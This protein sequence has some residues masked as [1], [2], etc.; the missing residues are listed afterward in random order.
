MQRRCANAAAIQ[1]VHLILHQR[2]E[3]R[4][5]QGRARQHER[6][7]LKSERLAGSGRHDGQHVVSVDH[8]PDQIFLTWTERGVTKMLL[9]CGVKIDH[10]NRRCHRC[11][12]LSRIDTRLGLLLCNRPA[13]RVYPGQIEWLLEA[14]MADL[15][16]ACTL[17]PQALRA[18]RE[19][20]LSDLMR[21]A[22]GAEQL[23]DGLRLRFATSIA[24]LSAIARAVAAAP[25]CCRSLQASST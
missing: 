9:Q 1:L 3:G 10:R 25:Y 5:H 20:L 17:S 21:K 18:R 13:G 6:R 24:T 22:D 11:R 14:R 2:D 16:V 4:D 19:G 7:Q 15:P 12:G 8:G 23:A